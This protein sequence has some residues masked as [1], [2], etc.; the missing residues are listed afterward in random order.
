MMLA[1]AAAISR[2]PKSGIG[3]DGVGCGEGGVGYG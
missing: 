3:I 2:N 1:I